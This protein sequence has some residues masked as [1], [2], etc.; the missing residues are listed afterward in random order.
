M[1]ERE[2]ERE[3]RLSVYVY[4]RESGSKKYKNRDRE[5][6]KGRESERKREKKRELLQ[7]IRCI[8]CRLLLHSYE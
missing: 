1:C 7:F 3:G 8:F 6:D 2:T 4:V 5:S